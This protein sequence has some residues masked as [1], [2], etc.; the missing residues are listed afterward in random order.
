MTVISQ[1]AMAGRSEELRRRGRVVVFTNGCFDLLHRG[2]IE[3]L[4]RA[5]AE[6][7]CLF[8][9]INGDESVRR[10]K[11]GDRPIQPA[12]DRAAI[13]DALGVVDEVSIFYQETPEELIG[14]VKP[15]VL[16]KGADYEAAGIAGAGRVKSWGGKVVTVPLIKG[17]GTA[18]LLEK[19]RGRPD[20]KN[21]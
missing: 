7:D 15:Q 5:R 13:V 16:V 3:L 14:K 20:G 10:L 1:E 19:I 17:K 11:G 18:L 9:G 12:E 8:V 4:K 2:H 6:G 21:G